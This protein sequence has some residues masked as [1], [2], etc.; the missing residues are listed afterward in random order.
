MRKTLL[1]GAITGI[2]AASS[3]H[4]QTANVTMYG[5]LILDA[6]VINSKTD[7]TPQAPGTPAVGAKQ[8]IYRVSSDISRFGMRGSESLGGGMTAIF[9]LESSITADNSGG[10][11]AARDTFIGLQGAWGTV[12]LGYFF[13]PYYETGGI[14]GNTPTFRT[15]ILAVHALWGNNGYNGANIQ[16]GS[17]A[18][19]EAN[20]LRYDSPDMSGFSGSVQ[21][22][23]RDV[24][25]DGGDLN[26]QRRHAYTLTG[27]GTY[28]NGPFVG[29]VAYEV[30][31]NLRDGTATNPKMQDQGLTVTASYDFGVVKIAGAYERLK[32]DVPA[33][34]DLKRNFWGIS[35]TANVGPGQLFAGFYK[36]NDGTGSS[37]CTTTGGIRSCPRIGGLTRG[38]DTGA[39]QWEISYTYP[40]SK[41][42][43]LFAGYIMIDNDHNA[44]YNFGNNPIPNV[45]G[46]NSQNAQGSNTGCGDASRPQ[47]F[48]VGIAHFF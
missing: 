32:Y 17:F 45:C 23:A 10:T 44:G 12:K 38:A 14:F 41:R 31:N 48:L 20:S 7:N 1:A 46:G 36:A 35:A 22:G 18:T 4:A 47:G 27:A 19:R 13:T 16:T 8:N 9:Q 29:G 34:G 5:A 21:I 37:S 33:G 15:S 11:L 2:L 30:H 28:K 43:L 39:Q 26:Q 6:E 40:L 25:G 42:T 3:A 24:G